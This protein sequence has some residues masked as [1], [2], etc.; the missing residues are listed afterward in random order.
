MWP[1]QMITISLDI[2]KITFLS[3][4]LPIIMGSSP[5]L[6]LLQKKI[7]LAG[8]MAAFKSCPDQHR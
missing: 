2:L 7:V 4:L 3:T 1:F 8:V 5:L 6:V